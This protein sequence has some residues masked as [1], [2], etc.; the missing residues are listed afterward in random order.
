MPKPVKRILVIDDLPA[1]VFI[2]QDRL[3]H[4][5]YVV[6]T[7]D[8]GNSGI[9]KATKEIPDLI[10]P[11]RHDRQNTKTRSGDRDTTRK[12]F[13]TWVHGSIR[14]RISPTVSI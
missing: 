2:L 10:R 14:L 13:K 7:A 6:L 5:G 3:E 9:E 8:G 4:E 11:T 1:N 12:F